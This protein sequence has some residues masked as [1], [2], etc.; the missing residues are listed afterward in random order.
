MW[1][2]T[3]SMAG[4][5]SDRPTRRPC[6]SSP[7]SL[8][9][10]SSL[11]R[12]SS[13]GGAISPSVTM[14]M[15]ACANQSSAHAAFQACRQTGPSGNIGLAYCHVVI[16]AGLHDQRELCCSDRCLTSLTF[17]WSLPMPV[18]TCLMLL[19]RSPRPQYIGCLKDSYLRPVPLLQPVP[20][21]APGAG[22]HP[23]RL[24]SC[25]A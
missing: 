15:S 2:H 13:L 9:A 22:P 10:T 20:G 17:A 1:S 16:P 7:R 11:F 8:R 12:T 24:R 21:I 23:C 25:T 4:L 6:T 14:R 3:C 18:G 19:L 5:V